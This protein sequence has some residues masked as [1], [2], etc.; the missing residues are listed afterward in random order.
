MKSD[1]HSILWMLGLGAVALCSCKSNDG[2][3]TDATADGRSTDGIHADLFVPKPDVRVDLSTKPAPKIKEIIPNNGFA[4][5]GIPVMLLGE[6]FAP[7][8][9][10][11]VEG[12]PIGGPFN[13][14]SAISMSFTMPENPYDA[15]KP[16][17]VGVM[18]ILN[19]KSS[20]TVDFFYNLSKPMTEKLKGSLLMNP[21][22]PLESYR[23]FPSDPIEGKVH[24]E[25]MGDA[26]A[27]PTVRAEVGLGPAGT[28]PNT[29]PTWRW[30]PATFKKNDGAYDVYSGTLKASLV[31]V[32]AVGYRFSPDDGK[33]WVYADTDETNLSYEPTKAGKLNAIQAPQDYCLAK[34]DC[35]ISAPKVTCKVDAA[36][37]K[38]NRC[39]ECLSNA[40][41]LGYPNAMGP[42]CATAQNLCYCAGASDCTSSANG[43]VCMPE[44]YCGCQ[45]TNNCVAPAK[46]TQDKDG[47]QMCR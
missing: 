35:V 6:N 45:D 9:A 30:F 44:K 8:I 20:N 36:N 2:G 25:A 13:V 29:D 12:K 14:A 43:A 39:V 15:K 38:N 1:R 4:S 22:T 37:K 32:Y 33:T 11:Y 28:D 21:S 41:C 7:G 46:C 23:D 16:D 17:K 19:Q 42:K 31:M 10:V 24:A 26:G 18:V 27:P 47:R 34:E 3:N 40:D 5:G